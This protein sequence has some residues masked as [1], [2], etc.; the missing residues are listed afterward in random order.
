MVV[1]A[2]PYVR[3]DFIAMGRLYRGATVALESREVIG[4]WGRDLSVL[5]DYGHGPKE[6]EQFKALVEQHLKMMAARPDSKADKSRVLAGRDSG[7]RAAKVWVDKVVC[8]L[9]QA[10]QLDGGFAIRL[11]E[12]VPRIKPGEIGPRIGSLKRLLNDAK[13]LL[14]AS[15]AIDARVAEADAV[16]AKVKDVEGIART[17]K[18]ASM[19]YTEELDC[20][21]GQI[22]VAIRRL[23]EAG[24]KA[25]L[26]GALALP[27]AEY[28]LNHLRRMHRQAQDEEPAAAP[29]DPIE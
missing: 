12:A 9:K 17:A 5:A 8:I 15:E 22:L 13:D 2:K 20:I 11:R 19:S 1:R 26:S 25:I 14:P 28:R 16:E 6:L 27:P 10:A 29:I 21:E 23:N 3:A 24:S 18:A 7:Y 4:R